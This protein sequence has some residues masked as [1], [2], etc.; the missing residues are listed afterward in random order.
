M[1]NKTDPCYACFLCASTNLISKRYLALNSENVFRNIGYS[2]PSI[3]GKILSAVSPTFA[4]AYKPV[5]ANKKYFKKR[6]FFCRNCSTGWAYPFFS[7]DSLFAYYKEFY[8]SNRD[9]AEARHLPG[10]ARP[11]NIQAKLSENRL[12]WIKQFVPS[13]SLVMDFGAGDCAASYVIRQSGVSDRVIVVDP[14]E[15]ARDLSVQY[16]ASYSEGLGDAPTVDFIYSAHSIEHVHDLLAVMSQ[17]A[18]KLNADG[19]LFIETPNIGDE[20]TWRALVHTPHTFL[21][22]R[23]SFQLIASRMGLSIVAMEST[24]PFWKDNRPWLQSNE[25]ADLR[26]LLQKS[27][28]VVNASDS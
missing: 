21:L 18:L 8:W 7:Q 2:V 23:Q 28:T 15:K 16:G 12:E 19:Y 1:S 22:S 6:L 17:L 13:F 4:S 14:S 27:S 11:N 24:G 26:I 3:I 9:Q 10:N 25:K 5:L 20:F